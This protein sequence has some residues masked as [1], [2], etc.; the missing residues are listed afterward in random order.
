VG[1]LTP[2]QALNLLA[3]WQERLRERP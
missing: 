1:S 2:L 3:A